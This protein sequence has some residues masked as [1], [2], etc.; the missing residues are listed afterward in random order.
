MK[1]SDNGELM[2]SKTQIPEGWRWVRLGDVAVMSQGG[3]P[4]KNCS[5]YWDGQ[6][7]FVTGAD[8]TEFRIG[9]RNARSFLTVEG[10]HSGFTVVC[11]P[12]A[13]LL[14]TRTR[15]GLAGMAAEIMG[16]SQDITCIV[17]NGQV[18][19][20]YLCRALLQLAPSLQRRSRGTTIQGITRDEVNSL[21]ILLPL[22]PEQRAIAA[23]LGSIDEA[24]EGAEVVI[25]ATERL[26]DALLYELLT[27][28]VPGWHTEWNDVPGLGTI[29]A[30]WDVV[31]L[32][33][34]CS[35]PEYGAG[36]PAR[37]FDPILPRYVR[38]TDLTDD[39]RLRTEDARSANPS[40]VKGYELEPGDL[41]FARSG[42]TVGKTY[43]YR[44]QDGPCVYAGYLIRFRVVP[45]VALP[46]FLGLWTHS[47]TYRRWVASMFRAG[48]QPNIN[49]MEYSSM[50]I[51]L[52][53]LREQ[54]TIAA[55][56]DSVDVTLEGARNDRDGLQML[57]ESTANAL[58]TGR[59]R[60]ERN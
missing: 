5:D 60:V 42:A 2:V 29:P 13:L 19:S 11:E 25:T 39:G 51:P 14:A 36:A 45:S 52:P 32:G 50:G 22:L 17:P 40:Q 7:P 35:P 20:D 59:V 53:S 12:G 28:G 54:R 26:R 3:T 44:P 30:C 4:R 8:L 43:L 31:R 6:I 46:E 41:L 38:I 37:P 27:R 23:V 18:H 57:K 9:R 58:L 49:A 47:D 1:R 34:V 56:L 15:V 10:L 16:A 48:A 24:I 21:L 33:D 55:V